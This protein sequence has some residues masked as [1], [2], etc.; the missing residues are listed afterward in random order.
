MGGPTSFLEASV[1][2]GRCASKALTWLPLAF[3]RSAVFCSS[4][5]ADTPPVA[6]QVLNAP[7]P[8]VLWDSYGHVEQARLDLGCWHSASVPLSLHGISGTFL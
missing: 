4:S 6:L 2:R 7:F 5:P 3:L 8:M 1:R